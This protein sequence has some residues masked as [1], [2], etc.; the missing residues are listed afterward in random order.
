MKFREDFVTNSSS[1]SYII[2]FAR[3]ADMDK[4]KPII[5]KYNI[6]LLDVNDVKHEMRWGELG[7][8]WAGACLYGT[9]E[10]LETHPDDKYIILEEC[11]DAY[12]E[13]DEEFDDY[14]IIYSYKFNVNE[15]ISNIT[16]ENGFADIDVAEGEGRNG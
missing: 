2:C 5:D 3:V 1:A 9:D 8:D 14:D 11:N 10:I 12:E 15:A 4:A 13:W 16:E 7:A 6:D